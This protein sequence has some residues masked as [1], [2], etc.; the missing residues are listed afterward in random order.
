ME[1]G[2]AD[3]GVQVSLIPGEAVKLDKSLH[4]FEI[5]GHI[6]AG[7]SGGLLVIM[8]ALGV[9]EDLGG[10][11]GIEIAQPSRGFQELG[12]VKTSGARGQSEQQSP[13]PPQQG[14][15]LRIPS[16]SVQFGRVL[17]INR[18]SEMPIGLLERADLFHYPRQRGRL[19][20]VLE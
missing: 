15:D 3:R 20:G 9:A 7:I 6:G 11:R 12:T 10:R 2:H 16:R 17:P 5:A 1:I 14:H 19:R 4:P 18:R 13:I 8:G